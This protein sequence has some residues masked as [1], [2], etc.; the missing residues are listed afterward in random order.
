MLLQAL[1]LQQLAGIDEPVVLDHFE[2]FVSC[3]LDAVGLATPVG[4]RSWF[5]YGVDPAPHRRGG[6]MTP[7]Q[8]AKAKKRKRTLAARGKVKQSF[9][10]ILDLLERVLGPDERLA[11]HT[12]AHP[13]YAPA[14]ASHPLAR[15]TVHRIF[16]NPKRGPKG[17]PRSREARIR[18]EAMFAVDLLHALWRHS[19]AHHRRETI[20]FSR[21]INA[22]V[23]EAFILVVWR[24]FVKGR[25]ERRPDRR[26]PAMLKG[27][28]EEPWTWDRVLAQRLFPGRIALPRS[29]LKVY[30]RD[31]DTDEAGPM[32][33]HRRRFAY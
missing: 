12:D 17:S 27:L 8:A 23:E 21:R 4:H 15:R 32:T 19:Q 18:D 16:P 26:T 24:N 1:A 14:L 20:A 13:A 31:W 6:R 25:S 9:A 7:S 3:Q 29:W 22:L 33:R 5:V 28:A 11:L 30:R 2:S 10:R